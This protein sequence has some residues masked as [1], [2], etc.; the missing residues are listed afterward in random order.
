MMRGCKW[1]GSP[2][3]PTVVDSVFATTALMSAGLT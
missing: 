3:V 2:A 1:K